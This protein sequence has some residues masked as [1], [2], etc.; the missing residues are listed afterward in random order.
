[1]EQELKIFQEYIAIVKRYKYQMLG[2]A[3]IG[4]VLSALI[5][6]NLPSIY[7]STATILIERQEMPQDIVRTM[8]SNYAEQRI[9]IINKKLMSSQNLINIINK[10]NLYQEEQKERRTIYPIVKSMRQAINMDIVGGKEIVNPRSGKVTQP[11]L[12][13][14]LSFE[15]K[16][17][18]SAQQVT[19]ELVNLYLN[20]NIKQRFKIVQGATKFLAHETGKLREEINTLDD[21]L[22]K[23]KEAHSSNLPEQN[24]LN[25]SRIERTEMQISEF[26]RQ[27]SSSTETELYLR[28][29]LDELAPSPTALGKEK[30]TELKTEYSK[31]SSKYSIEHP[32]VKKLKWEIAHLKKILKEQPEILNAEAVQSQLNNPDYIQIKARLIATQTEIREMR[33]SRDALQNRL[34]QYEDRVA[35]APQVEREYKSLMREYENATLKYRETKAK[36]REARMAQDME[37]NNQGDEFTLLEPPLLPEKH[38]KPNRPAI[39]F[40]GFLASIALAFGFLMAKE[41]LKPKIYTPSRLASVTGIPPLIS[42]PYL[43]P[44]HN[45]LKKPKIILLVIVGLLIVAAIFAYVMFFNS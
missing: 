41:G 3:L 35:G 24:Q 12:A 43:K 32:D 21:E 5:A 33:S 9:Q 20:E 7:K 2:I 38:F 39:M 10:F 29:Q 27:I 23:F 11:T 6:A 17:P 25:L 1:M 37:E 31:L 45:L 22:T 36:Q 4:F 13:F 15:S 34:S 40:L 16:S 14:T 42:I 18:E 19:N 26:R 30:L 28:T 44:Q 8:V